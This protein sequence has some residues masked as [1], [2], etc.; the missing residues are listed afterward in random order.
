MALGKQ[1]SLK[2]DA[3]APP[4]TLPVRPPPPTPRQY[5]KYAEDKWYPGKALAGK[6]KKQTLLGEWRW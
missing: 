3:H 2:M 4:S 1:Q 6:E 5:A